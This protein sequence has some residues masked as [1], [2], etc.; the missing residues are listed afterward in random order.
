MDQSDVFED[1]LARVR[2]LGADAGVK[3]EVVES[4]GGRRVVRRHGI[5]PPE[6]G[7]ARVGCE[8]SGGPRTG[9]ST[10]TSSG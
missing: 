1:A 8:A 7:G 2:E 5:D 6:A 10:L 4:L 9:E 3:A